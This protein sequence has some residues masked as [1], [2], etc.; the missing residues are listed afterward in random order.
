MKK[1]RTWLL[2]LVSL[3]LGVLACGFP[4]P[5]VEEAL[6]RWAG[7]ACGVAESAKSCAAR[8]DAYRALVTEDAVSVR[9]VEM[10]LYT[11]QGGGGSDVSLLGEYDYAL[12]ETA[13]GTVPGLHGWLHDLSGSLLPNLE[14]QSGIEVILIGTE[15]YSLPAGATSWVKENLED[16][17]LL[18]MGLLFGIPAFLGEL[19]DVYAADGAFTVEAYETQDASGQAVLV[20]TLALDLEALLNDPALLT[21]L[22]EPVAPL[23]AGHGIED[24]TE[25]I[26]VAPVLRPYLEGSELQTRLSIGQADGLL[27]AFEQT[28]RLAF[29]LSATDPEALPI[30]LRYTI[31]GVFQYGAAVAPIVAPATY[32]EGDG[33]LLDGMN[34]LN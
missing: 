28:A 5:L 13:N 10:H 18:G 7:P 4:L 20:Q 1:P 27:H 24:P 34:P 23:L 2:A 12:L 11:D 14:D 26:A 16:S 9:D 6:D 29:D 30:E 32:V 8:Q 21:L 3:S 15:G 17:A 19:P 22:A 25:L 33:G 31:S